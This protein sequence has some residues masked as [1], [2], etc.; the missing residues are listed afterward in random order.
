MHIRIPQHENFD[1]YAC[2]K[3]YKKYQKLVGD[4]VSFNQIIKN[5]FF[6]SFYDDKTLV[7]CI[8]V[9]EKQ[10]KLFM[11]GFAKRG[12]HKF[13]IQAVKKIFD[14]F[15]ADIYAQSVRKPA[16]LLLLKCGFKKISDNMF[17]YYNNG[18]NR[19]GK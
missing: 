11:N 7:G 14:W 1:F 8:Y 17:V 12:F 13:N 9:F 2:R 10:K 19:K 6:Y 18:V 4:N 16:I 3:L 15:N 5:T